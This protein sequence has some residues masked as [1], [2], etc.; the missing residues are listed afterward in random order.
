MIA[1]AGVTAYPGPGIVTATG[2]LVS[3]L[4][5][6]FVHG[7]ACGALA[8]AMLHLAPTR[9][10]AQAGARLPWPGVDTVQFRLQQSGS[11]T[12]IRHVGR[13][14][15]REV[16]VSAAWLRGTDEDDEIAMV[17]DTSVIA[18]TV[19][20]HRTLLLLQSYEIVTEGGSAQAAGRDVFLVF[21]SADSMLTPFA[22][23]PRLARGRNRGAGC[24]TA[25]DTSYIVADVNGDGVRD[26]GVTQRE[27]RCDP[28]EDGQPGR[29][30]RTVDPV[31]W[32]VSSADGG[33]TEQDAYDGLLPPE[34]LVLPSRL[35]KQPVDF[36]LELLRP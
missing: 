34:R 13:D 2:V 9:V 4:F 17:F 30:A 21:D 20:A 18:A 22:L 15:T 12:E 3:Q 14:A 8:L 24:W 27:V 31:R 23:G 7:P 11:R 36:V 33:W 25:W 16:S 29:S 19:D 1:E 28:P 10:S 26:L 5:T 6:S 35:A 32:W